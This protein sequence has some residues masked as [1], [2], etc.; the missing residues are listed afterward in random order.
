[1]RLAVAGGTGVVGRYV[2][3]AA[4]ARG[5][6]VVVLA[7]SRGV[8]VRTG[9]GLDAALAD[10]QAVVDATNAGMTDRAAASAFFADVAARLQEAAKRHGVGHVVTLSIV[11]IDRVPYGYYGAKLRHEEAALGGPVPA[12]V[13]RATQFH[14]LAAQWIRRNL[15][16]AVARVP[17]MRVQTVAARTVGA[18]L[19]ELATAPPAG[20][21]GELAGPETAD[22]YELARAFA[23]RHAPGITVEPD[24]AGPGLSDGALLPSPG[25]RIEGPTFAAWLAS[26]DAAALAV[27]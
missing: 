2:V 8:D 27:C 16:G 11:G 7:R 6:E 20:H 17:R 19:A 22:L 5:H 21:A 24:E 26:A 12:T 1:M 25:A 23:A 14:E 18:A 3:E 13:L 15:D 9:A 4:R 10:V